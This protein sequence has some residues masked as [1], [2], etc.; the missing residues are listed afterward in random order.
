MK[1]LTFL[2]I[3]A[4]IILLNACNGPNKNL[5]KSL[6][7]PKVERK[8]QYEVFLSKTLNIP[9]PTDK[10]SKY[11]DF[12][13]FNDSLFY[14]V[15]ISRSLTI[16]VYDI[17]KEKFCYD[18]KVP[19]YL[20]RTKRIENLYVQ[21]PDSIFFLESHPPSI[22]LINSKGE[23]LKRFDAQKGLDE[24][25]NNK[26]VPNP[27]SFVTLFI[28]NNPVFVSSDNELFT[29]AHPVGAEIM[30]GYEEVNRIGIYDISNDKWKKFM[31]KPEGIL[32]EKGKLFYTYDLSLPYFLVVDS[33]IYIS[34]PIDHDIYTY[35]IKTGKLLS[36]TP[37]NSNSNETLSAPLSA[38]KIEDTQQSWNF[39]VQTPFYGPLFYNKKMKMFTRFYHFKQALKMQNGKINNGSKRKGSIIIFD[40]NLNIVGETFFKNGTLG[41]LKNIPMSDGFLMGINS[42]VQNN[43]NYLIYKYKYELKRINDDI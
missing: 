14:G 42:F 33:L 25:E 11:N 22:Y 10:Y 40:N 29:I 38:S 30:T 43:D 9:I 13:I 23:L 24:F 12:A 8:N 3:V 41:V 32:K 36:K 26:E 39:R 20:I 4:I 6:K 19:E 27:L 2:I 35:D 31:V 15:N 21:S 16:D 7:S 37:G 1:K 18:I 28:Y 17:V 34:Y 5:L